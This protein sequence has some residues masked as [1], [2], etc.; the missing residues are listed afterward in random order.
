MCLKST[1][2]VYLTNGP[3]L[4]EALFRIIFQQKFSLEIK[5]L[6][7]SNILPIVKTEGVL[8]QPKPALKANSHF[9]KI[10]MAHKHINNRTIISTY[11]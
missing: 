10:I 6:L 11:V 2:N 8:S 5:D 1:T 3:L 9:N 7:K 4:S